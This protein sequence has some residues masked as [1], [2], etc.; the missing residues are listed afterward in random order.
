M[1]RHVVEAMFNVLEWKREDLAFIECPGKHFHTGKNAKRDCRVSLDNAPTIFCLH[2]SCSSVIEEANYKMRRAIWESN[3]LPK[4]EFTEEEKNKV[5]KDL[6]GKRK[7]QDLRDWASQNKDRLFEKYSW[8]IA[9]VFHESPVMSNSPE[10]DGKLFL[11]LY[12]LNDTLWIGEPTDSGRE[13]KKDHFKPVSEWI[14]QDIDFHFT[15]PSTFKAGSFS[16]SNEN[17]LSRPFLVIESDTLTQDETCSLFKWMKGFLVLR[18]IIFTGGKSMHGWF[19]FPR[20]DLFEKLKVCLPELGCDEALFKPSQ[21]VRMPGIKRN[22]QW[23]CLYWF[24][25][26]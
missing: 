8:P 4:R 6:A 24:N 1:S 22:D 20:L 7:D 2:S 16:R 26:L 19:E 10:E 5:K 11:R 21:P 13:E 25:N 3:P 18:A 12:N 15:C 9:D 17:V 14:S 23:Q